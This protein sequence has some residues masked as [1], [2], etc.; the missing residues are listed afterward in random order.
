[1]LEFLLILISIF[2]IWKVSSSFDLAANFLTRNMGDG[3]KGPTVNAI[4]SSLPELTISTL[5]LFF[6]KDINGFSAGFATIIGSSAFNIALI[7]IIAYIFSIKKNKNNDFRID[8]NI[9]IQDG[10]FLLISICLLGLGFLIGLNIYY[11]I[12]LIATYI[13]YIFFIYRKRTSSTIK[14]ENKF[15]PMKKK[16][17]NGKK[18]GYVKSLINLRI[19]SILG[20]KKIDNLNSIIVIVVS[21]LI[22]TLACYVLVNVVENISEMLEINLFITAFFIAAISS[23][24]PD[25]ILSI[26]DAENNK[27]NDSFSNTYG[28]NIFD[29]CV[30]I[31]LPVL[32]YSIF[33]DPIS[34]DIP[35]ERFGLT[36]FGDSIFGG[37]LLIWST[38]ILFIFTALISIIYS[39]GKINKRNIPLIF[40]LY[41]LY[42]VALLIF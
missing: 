21:V 29:I 8:R 5:F 35:I 33:N 41:F 6:Y 32:F 19:Y 11:A 30:G 7:P 27:F 3:I 20:F 13:F 23:S 25:T 40:M 18:W 14:S 12:L 34:L 4:A 15:S 42:I 10:I 39:S 28:S 36:K 31:G 37:N 38:I 16:F 17:E 1:M 2:L 22:I 26:K 24:I 9:V